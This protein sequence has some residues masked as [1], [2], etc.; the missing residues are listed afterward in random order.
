MRAC[1]AVLLVIVCHAAAMAGEPAPPPTRLDWDTGEGKSYWIPALEI[2][3]FIFSLNA[4]NRVLFGGDDYDTTWDTFTHNLKTAPVYDKDP[5]SVNQLGHPYQGSVYYGFARSAGLEYWESLL[6][7]L[8]GSFLWETWGETTPPS[9]NDYVSTTI[10]GS[11]VGEALFRMSSLLLEGGGEKPGFW[12]ELGAAI[13]SPSTGFNRLVF[14]DRFKPIFPS[15]DPEIFLRLRVGGTLTSNITN[16]D[17]PNDARRQ[18]ASLDYSI[19][20]GL[21][22]KPGYRYTRPFDYFHFEFTIVPN[23][24]SVGN[25]VENL[26]IRG[27]LAGA[28][29]EW[30]ADYRGVWGLFGAYEYL[31]PQVFRVATTSVSLGTVGQW[32]L[33]R[34]IALQPT[35]L[36]GVGFGA[37]GTV[38]DRA[39]RDYHYGLI[40]ELVAGARLI[41]GE[42]AMLDASL[43]Q[44]FVAGLSSAGGGSDSFGP[45]NITRANAGFTVRLFGPHAIGIQYV[46]STRDARF[47]DRRDRHQSVETVTLSY[48]FL[49]HTRFGAAEWRPETR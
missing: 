34:S 17:L 1:L 42:R 46:V 38:A 28:R 41:F 13:I 27:L 6:Y 45:E 8:A 15:R 40:P 36:G 5:F 3:G 14:G 35:L 7:T 20:Y 49:G 21:P 37:S 43:R 9:I 12:R 11:F 31:S 18:E 10:G 48:N 2:T 19:T 30:G 24:D 22:G 4:I 26:A 44:F 33:S 16:E 25:A 47:P 32:W 23:A 39:E 29:Y